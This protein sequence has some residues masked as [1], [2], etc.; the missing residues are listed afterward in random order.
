MGF[1]RSGR[2]EDLM[3]PLFTSDRSAIVRELDFAGD[4]RSQ[5]LVNGSGPA[6]VH[7]FSARRAASGAP[8]LACVFT[9]HTG[10]TTRHDEISTL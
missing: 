6:M 2:G 5:T 7:E 3:K 4:I 1:I 8:D 10:N 9:D